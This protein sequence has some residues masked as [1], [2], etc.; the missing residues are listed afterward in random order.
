MQN[1]RTVI[2][3]KPFSHFG[4]FSN[5]CTKSKKPHLKSDTIT[6]LYGFNR[7]DKI[8]EITGDGNDYGARIYEA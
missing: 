3:Y 5:K 2:N 1:L 6:Y 4:A 7:K 8:D